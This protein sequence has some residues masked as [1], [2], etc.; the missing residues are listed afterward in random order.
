MENA[1]AMPP[2]CFWRTGLVLARA[3]GMVQMDKGIIGCWAHLPQLASAACNGTIF[4]YLTLTLTLAQPPPASPVLYI[5]VLTVRTEHCKVL[6]RP[7][8]RA[9]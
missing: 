3:N 9:R 6:I 1:E 4:A 5:Q 7:L 8:D 2:T